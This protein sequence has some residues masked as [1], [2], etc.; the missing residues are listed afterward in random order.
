MLEQILEDGD[1]ADYRYRMMVCHIPVVYVDENGYFEEYRNEWTALLNE[2]D[3]DIGLSGHK[4]VLWPLIPGQVMSNAT[5]VYN[6]AYSKK[7]NEVEGGYL[8][9]FNFPVFLAGRRSLQQAGGT[10]T[11]G[12]D[13][14]VC[15]HT[16]VDWEIGWQVSNYVNSQ[17]E[18]V[19]GHYPFAR[20]FFN[21]IPTEIKRQEK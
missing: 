11:G 12:N 21:D 4:H 17:G 7:E 14:Y 1:Y 10:Q 19:S 9:D 5:L 20:G 15:L 8:I 6:D 16:R 2:M 18:I 13:Q 3:L